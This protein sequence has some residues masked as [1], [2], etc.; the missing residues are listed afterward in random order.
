MLEQDFRYDLASPDTILNR[1]LGKEIELERIV[2]RDGDKKETIKGI[3]LSNSG[4]RVV[5][6]GGKILINPPGSPVLGEL[7]E[8][9]L[10]KPTLVW[11]LL[12][13]QAGKHEGEISYL[14]AGM[15]WQADYILV[16]DKDDAKAD[17]TAW[18]TV[19]NNSGATYKDAKLKLIAGDVHR[20]PQ[21]GYRGGGRMAAKAMMLNEMDGGMVEKTFFEYHMYTLQRL[22]TLASNSSKQVEMASAA[23]I[24]LKKIYIYDG[25]QGVQWLSYGDSG[26]WDPNYGMSS[27]KKISV[28]FEIS[29]KKADGLGIPLPKGRVRVYKK[30]DEGSLQMAGEDSIDHTPKDEKVRV[31]MGESFD[32]VGERKRVN[33]QSD[34]K[35]RRFEETFEIRLRNHKEAPVTVTVVEHLYR[36]TNWKVADASQKWAKRDA[37]TIEFAVPVA[38]DGES[39][40]TYTVKYS[41]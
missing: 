22:T 27:G 37:Q 38:K 35:G 31:K 34:V 10:T 12:S 7:P 23:D 40:V 13:K 36:W 5:Q 2:G 3:L 9:L 4:G 19:S 16:A 33:Y 21:R 39:V 14:T 25:A 11:K 26:Y 32:L 6:S 41:W 18:V 30:D 15:S 24:P 28:H 8:G 29:N 20:A 17:L 1:Y